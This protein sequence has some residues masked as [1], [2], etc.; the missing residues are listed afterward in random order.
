[1]ARKPAVIEPDDERLSLSDLTDRE[2][3]LQKEEDADVT[4]DAED[5]E[6]ANIIGFMGDEESAEDKESAEF[7]DDLEQGLG[8]DMGMDFEEDDMDEDSY[9]GAGY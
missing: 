8:S 7:M 1:M 4:S 3:E 5:D 6:I 2:L 9:E